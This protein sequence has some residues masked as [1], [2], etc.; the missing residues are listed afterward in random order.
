MASIRRSLIEKM[1]SGVMRGILLAEAD[2]LA[3]GLDYEAA[4]PL[5]RLL[6]DQVLTARLRRFRVAMLR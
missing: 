5:E 2:I 4:P 6:I 3:K 1:S